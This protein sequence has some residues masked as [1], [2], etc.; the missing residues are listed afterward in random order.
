MFSKIVGYFKEHLLEFKKYFV[1]GLSGTILDIVSLWILKQFFNLVPVLAVVV[2]Q[3]FV[4]LYLFWLNKKISFRVQGIARQQ[5]LRFILVFG[6]NYILAVG[7]MWV[8]N[9]YLGYHYLMVRI[10]N[11]A[12]SVSWNFWLYKEWVYKTADKQV[13]L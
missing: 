13:S 4:L 12:M 2:N 9:Q 3:V 11:I 6:G 8:F 5:L 10:I 1:I 7:W